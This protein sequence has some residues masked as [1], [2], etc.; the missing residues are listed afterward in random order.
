MWRGLRGGS[1]GGEGVGGG[2]VEGSLLLFSIL[3]MENYGVAVQS[4]CCD[5]HDE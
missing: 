5:E 2:G 4:G 3:F 1:L